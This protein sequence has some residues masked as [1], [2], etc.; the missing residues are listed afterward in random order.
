MAAQSITLPTQADFSRWINTIDWVP[1]TNNTPIISLYL[2]DELES[3]KLNHDWRKKEGA[4]N[5][6]SFPSHL[7]ESN[8]IFLLGDL[9]ICA[10]LVQLEADAQ[11]KELQQHWAHLTIH[12]TLHLLG[13]DHIE[14]KEAHEMETIEIKMM[15][16]L[17]YPNPYKPLFT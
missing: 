16:K 4:T 3:A 9:A 7:T 6:L 1:H 8:P 14:E 10:P 13:Y 17:G 5:I 2:V 15:K 12:G 11:Q